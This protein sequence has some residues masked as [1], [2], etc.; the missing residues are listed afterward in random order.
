KYYDSVVK[1]KQLTKDH[2]EL[3]KTSQ[4][5]KIKY[6]ELQARYDE[7]LIS[8]EKLNNALKERINNPSADQTTPATATTPKA[9]EAHPIQELNQAPPDSG[10]KAEPTPPTTEPPP[11]PS[12]K[13]A[14]LN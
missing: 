1:L 8:Q 10:V 12:D 4:E 2:D 3:V 11:P 6:D 5:A 7:L 9:A 14:S 13:K